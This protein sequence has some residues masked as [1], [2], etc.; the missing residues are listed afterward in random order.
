MPFI[1]INVC[2]DVESN[3][4]NPYSWYIIVIDCWRLKEAAF[5]SVRITINFSTHFNTNFFVEIQFNRMTNF[6]QRRR[7]IHLEM[8]D[9]PDISEPTSKIIST[10]G[11]LFLKF[12]QLFV[13][14]TYF[15]IIG[16]IIYYANSKETKKKR[17]N[18]TSI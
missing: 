4:I 9:V 11:P 16:N 1:K 10:S 6:F 2:L 15:Q 8:V 12:P 17:K 13:I 5:E 18:C 3:Y 14:Y 7:Q